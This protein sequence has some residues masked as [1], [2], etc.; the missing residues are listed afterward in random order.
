MPRRS[1]TRSAASANG[2]PVDRAGFTNS[3][4]R[5]IRPDL[6]RD[7]IHEPY[8]KIGAN[9]SFRCRLKVVVA[10]LALLVALGGTSI[11][12]VTALPPGSGNTAALQNSAVTTKKIANKAV[13]LSKLA[14]SARI[15]GAKGD[16]GPKGDIG[17][18]D[19]YERSVASFA[20]PASG[21]PAGVNT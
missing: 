17:P 3:S 1:F 9:K 18:S 19:G 8:G 6:Q 2:L 4:R 12:A 20:L 13:T 10:C 21:A 5:F 7:R 16:P 15:P 11:A 14:P